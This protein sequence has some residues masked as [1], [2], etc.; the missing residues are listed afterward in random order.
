MDRRIDTVRLILRSHTLED[1]AELEQCYT[2]PEVV[3]FAPYHPE[4]DEDMLALVAIIRKTDQQYLGNVYLEQDGPHSMEIG[5]VLRR[6][7]W[8]N[9]YAAEA[10]SALIAEALAGGIRRIWAECD[11][12]NILCWKLL[13]RLGFAREAYLRQNVWF[14]KDEQGNPIWKDTC[15]YALCKPGNQS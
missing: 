11:P 9:G 2:D 5:F 10:C 14:E 4:T 1:R 7:A 6:D 15:R 3:R 12:D 13:E 8:G